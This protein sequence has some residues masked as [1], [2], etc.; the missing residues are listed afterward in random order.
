MEEIFVLHY[1]GKY[2]HHDIMKMPIEERIWCI[3]RLNE[4]K[5]REE[6]SQLKAQGF[7]EVRQTK[8]PTR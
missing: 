6:D 4:Q 3:K 1:V 8:Y 2:T 7:Q 5:K